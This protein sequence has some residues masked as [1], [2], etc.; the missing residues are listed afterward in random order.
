MSNGERKA[1]ARVHAL[2]VHFPVSA[3]TGAA[4]LQW[5]APFADGP[6]VLG[7]DLGAATAALAWT[8]LAFATA[9]ALAGLNELTALPDDDAVVTTA[10]RHLLAMGAAFTCF[11]LFALARPDAGALAAPP[12]VRH[13]LAFLGF[14]AMLVGGHFGG[15]L[16]LLRGHD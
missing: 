1:R 15:R 4:F 5:F 12:A 11:L 16:V 10:N 8:G 7:I 6:V 14:A 3:W 13:G 2:L 9:A